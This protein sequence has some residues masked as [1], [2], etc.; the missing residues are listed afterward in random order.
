[1]TQA[2]ILIDLQNDYFDGGR[3]PLH[4][5]DLAVAA[6][7]T[8]LAAFRARGLPVLHIQHIIPKTPAPFFERLRALNKRKSWGWSALAWASPKTP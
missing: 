4:Q 5:P 8:L 6:A 1:M 7:A 3:M 2:L